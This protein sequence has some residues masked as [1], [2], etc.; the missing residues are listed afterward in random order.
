MTKK[1]KK[2]EE[3]IN[4]QALFIEELMEEYHK[5]MLKHVLYKS[6][7]FDAKVKEARNRLL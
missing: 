1:E 4:S 7:V 5:L 3:V 6:A 2:M